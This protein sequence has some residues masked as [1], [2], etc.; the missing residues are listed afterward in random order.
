VDIAGAGVDGACDVADSGGVI[1]RY[2]FDDG[3]GRGAAAVGLGYVLAVFDGLFGL[4]LVGHGGSFGR[5]SGGRGLQ[6]GSGF[7]RTTVNGWRW[8]GTLDDTAPFA[9]GS[10]FAD[11]LPEGASGLR[12]A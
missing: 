9:V 8:E 7:S 11:R 3:G 6:D 10:A 1:S 4:G 12:F 5:G 2:S